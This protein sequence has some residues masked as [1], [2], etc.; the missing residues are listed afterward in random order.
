[1]KLIALLCL[2]FC[3]GVTAVAAEPKP[4]TV[5]AGQEFK[6]S[7][8]SNPTT[9]YG[10]QFAKHPEAQV[11]K[12]LGSEFKPAQSRLMGAGGTQVW[13]FKALAQGKTTLALNYVR[14]WEKNTPPAQRTNFVVVITGKR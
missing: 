3:W 9:G 13:T 1:M 6:I 10:W 8:P 4:I 11:L 5:K 2:A 7:L 12:L 14:A